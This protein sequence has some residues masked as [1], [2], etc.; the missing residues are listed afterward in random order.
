MMIEINLVEIWKAERKGLVPKKVV[1]HGRT[2]TFQ[3]TQWVRSG[4][5]PRQDKEKIAEYEGVPGLYGRSP[6]YESMPKSIGIP[7]A[8]VKKMQEIR[9]DSMLKGIEIGCT[10]KRRKGELFLGKPIEGESH[11]V[12]IK[13]REKYGIYHTHASSIAVNSLSPGDICCMLTMGRAYVPLKLMMGH[14]CTTN[15]LWCAVASSDTFKIAKGKKLTERADECQ[16]YEEEF[17]DKSLIVESA[18]YGKFCRNYVKSFCDKYKIKLYC[19]K[20]GDDLK[21]YDGTW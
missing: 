14:D 13:K 3:R 4:E 17:K 6:K 10:I 8:S 1:V 9:K 15:T 18:D 11:H 2:K 16:R 7:E 20:L 12:E 21:E 19:G 5:A